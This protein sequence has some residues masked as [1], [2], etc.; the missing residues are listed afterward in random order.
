MQLAM[1]L[2]RTILLCLALSS[3]WQQSWPFLALGEGVELEARGGLRHP[4]S[5]STPPITAHGEKVHFSL[6][7]FRKETSKAKPSS[8]EG[9]DCTNCLLGI[10][11][12]TLQVCRWPNQTGCHSVVRPSDLSRVPYHSPNIAGLLLSI[13]SIT[14][15][16]LKK[17]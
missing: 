13:S 12:P 11:P 9:M 6:A 8:T 14:G 16:H 15:H 1:R 5:P 2:S 4:C 17:S 3:W 10:E 7:S